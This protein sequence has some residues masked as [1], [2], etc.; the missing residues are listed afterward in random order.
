MHRYGRRPS[1]IAHEHRACL[2]LAQ[3]LPRAC[4][5]RYIAPIQSLRTYRRIFPFCSVD[6]AAA[7]FCCGTV[8]HIVPSSSASV[9]SLHNSLYISP[10]CRRPRHYIVAWSAVEAFNSCKYIFMCISSTV[11]P[12]SPT[13][14]HLRSAPLCKKEAKLSPYVY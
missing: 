2:S 9:L 12:S 14:C 3:L 8:P 10:Y 6:F 7:F 11:P 13:C 5:D 4:S 1:T